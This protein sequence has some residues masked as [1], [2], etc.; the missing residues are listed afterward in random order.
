VKG[1]LVHLR[2]DEGVALAEMRD[3]VGKNALSEDMVHALGEVVATVARESSAKVLILFGL[4]EVFSSGAPRELLQRLARGEL[5]P[6]DISLAAALLDAP[7]P[8][9]AAMEGHATGGG[10]ALGLCA[11]I[12]VMARES[13]Y[14]ATFMNMGFTPGMGM[15]CLLEHVLSPAMAHEALYTGELRLGRDFEGKSGIGHVVAR[16]E[17]RGR[18]LDVA[19]RI[20]DKPRDALVLLKAALAGPRRVAFAR[21]REVE[22]RMHAVTFSRPE[23]LARIETD[24]LEED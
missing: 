19:R 8:V 2:F 12:V 6:A 21:A 20:A 22:S 4:P 10:L 23:T 1:D 7:I 5:A 16:A 3:E 11:D 18:A 24:Y 15:T 14:G 13:R 17:V 9:I